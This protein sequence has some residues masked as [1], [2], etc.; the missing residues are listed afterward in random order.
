MALSLALG[1]A[2][3]KRELVAPLVDEPREGEVGHLHGRITDA[4]TAKP[5]LEVIV[6]V[7]NTDISCGT[8][9]DGRYQIAV[10][11]GRYTLTTSY[12]GYRA[13]RRSVTLEPG[14]TIAGLDFR[15]QVLDLPLLRGD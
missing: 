6:R 13:Q 15:L 10:Q 2:C 4:R 8:D 11:P 3:A 7:Y 14:Q 5:L 1:A 9:R 12:A